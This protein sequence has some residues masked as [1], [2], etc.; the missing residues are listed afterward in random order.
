MT[1]NVHCGAPYHHPAH[2]WQEGSA[3]DIERHWCSG[4][5]EDDTD[6]DNQDE[7]F[8]RGNYDAP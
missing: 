1:N 6:I 2:I 4:E 3:G 8:A 5:P 7:L